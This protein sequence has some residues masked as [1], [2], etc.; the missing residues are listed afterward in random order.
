MTRED[1]WPPLPLAEWQ[2][3]LD[4][5]HMWTQ[6]AGKV[7][8]A[9]A[10]HVNHWWQVPL[11]VSARGLTTSA[12]PVRGGNF[13]IEFDFVAHELRIATSWDQKCSM[14]LAPQSVAEFYEKFMRLLDSAGI[15]VKIWP[16][17]VE[18]PNPIR[19][20]QDTVH[21]SY[22]PAYANRCWR[23]LS[24]VDAVLK[25]FRCGFIGKASPVHFFWGSFDLAATRF[26]GRRAPERPGADRMTR[27]AYSHEVIS[28]GWWPGGGD[29]TEPMFYAYA[30]PE[31][32]GFREATVRPPQAFYHA[33]LGEFLLPYEAVRTSANPRETLLE[34]LQSTYEAGANLGQWD[35]AALERA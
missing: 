30:V 17:P 35:R 19:F 12:I 5:L 32:G 23:V 18:V 1:A 8:L 26:S 25:E 14:P 13:E 10:P 28:A 11:Y 33:Q 20:D 24:S 21:A 27:E 7:R 4:T 31:P 16:M 34:F 9:L 29:I 15:S 2:P 6:M 3:T 22:D